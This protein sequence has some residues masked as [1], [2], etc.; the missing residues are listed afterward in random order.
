MG[1]WPKSQNIKVYKFLAE[2]YPK[3]K[4]KSR[5]PLNFCPIYMFEG[6]ED[7]REQ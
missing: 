2:Y 6:H 5:K 3:K 7:C 4:K 1:Q